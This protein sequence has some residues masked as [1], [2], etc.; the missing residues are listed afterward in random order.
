MATK[1]VIIMEQIT[2]IIMVTTS[3]QITAIMQGR[4]LDRTMVIIMDSI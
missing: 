3:G 4:I 2:V 1:T